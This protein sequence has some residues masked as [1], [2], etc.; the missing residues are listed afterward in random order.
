METTN[1]RKGGLALYKSIGFEQVSEEGRRWFGNMFNMSLIHGITDI[2]ME[3]ETKD[4][5]FEKPEGQQQ[6]PPQRPPG[7]I[8]SPQ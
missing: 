6:G 5:K 8:P 7:P 3:M 1:S 4:A 2:R